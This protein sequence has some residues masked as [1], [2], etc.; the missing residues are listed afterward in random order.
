MKKEKTISVFDLCIKKACKMSVKELF[1]WLELDLN[2]YD[3]ISAD[4][5]D[6]YIRHNT[7]GF[8]QFSVSKKEF[9][10]WG[11]SQNYE[12]CFDLK[13]KADWRSFVREMQMRSEIE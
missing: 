7:E 6:C 11:N 5:G 10:K 12:K 8:I 2:D 1:Q 4:L 13:N 9:D 3:K